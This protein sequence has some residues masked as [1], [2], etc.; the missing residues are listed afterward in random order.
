MSSR[1]IFDCVG[2][3]GKITLTSLTTALKNSKKKSRAITMSQLAASSDDDDDEEEEEVEEANSDEEDNRYADYPPLGVD[4]INKPYLNL[5][6][7]SQDQ[8]DNEIGHEQGLL[9]QMQ[10]TKEDGGML[11]KFTAGQKQSVSSEVKSF[12]DKEAPPDVLARKKNFKNCAKICA[13]AEFKQLDFEG[14]TLLITMCEHAQKDLTAVHRIKE[15]GKSIDALKKASDD[16]A[17]ER[18]NNALIKGKKRARE[19]EEAEASTPPSRVQR[20]GRGG[21][22][23]RGRGRG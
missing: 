16:V 6:K 7:A 3:S 8:I 19:K 12:K 2:G 20:T 13:T 18:R 17:E 5:M 22:R 4:G 11:V 15:L 10:Q 23:G 9:D 21:G 1:N 14:L